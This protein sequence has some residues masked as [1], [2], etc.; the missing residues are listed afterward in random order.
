MPTILRAPNRLTAEQKRSTTTLYL[1]GPFEDGDGSPTPPRSWR[2]DIIDA[3]DDLDI[4]II[5]PRSER[6]PQLEVG[7]P[8][9]RGAY[10]WQCAAAFDADVVIVWIPTGRHAPTA[11]LILGHLG[12]KRNNAKKGSSVVVGG[13]GWN[14]LVRLYAQN[15]RLFPVGGVLAEVIRIARLQ[16][17]KASA[18][19][20]I[21]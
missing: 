5:D 21:S 14:G 9:R 3:F 20:G 7:S 17:E 2:D 1:A 11:M 18:T 12:A 19:K 16:I 6:W 4:T 15:Q 10:E 13:D 8:G